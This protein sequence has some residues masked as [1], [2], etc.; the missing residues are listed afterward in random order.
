MMDI[1][2]PST[3]QIT[4]RSAEQTTTP[5]KLL[6]IRIAEIAGKTINAEVK[7]EPTRFIARTIIIAPSI[8]SIEL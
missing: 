6:N 3:E 7:R 2:V 8:E 5:R 1:N 4:E